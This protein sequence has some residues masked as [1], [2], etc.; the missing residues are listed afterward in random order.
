MADRDL[1][2]T[3]FSYKAYRKLKKSLGEFDAVVEC[4]EIAIREFIEQ[5]E[6]KGIQPYIQ[7]LSKKHK[8]KVD[9]VDFIKFTS[10]I[11]QYYIA[12]VA[13]QFEQFLEDFKGEWEEYFFDVQWKNRNDGEAKLD[14]CLKNIQFTNTPIE[15]DNHIKYYE[16]Y[17]HVR[18][19]MAHTDRDINKLDSAFKKIE[20]L[21]ITNLSSPKSLE[22]IDFE[23]FHVLTNVVKHIAFVI[24]SKSK[25]DNQRIAE[26]LFGLSKENKARAYKGLKKLKADNVRYEKALKSFA[27][28]HFGRFSTNDADD[29]VNKLKCLLA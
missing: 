9:D 25:P 23:D 7:E 18:N 8:V 27:V 22:N 14:N 10:R 2:I 24:C 15:F 16:Y 26:I 5:V 28:T 17:R 29:I 12:S 13:Q 6:K 4:N 1:D 21:F 11:R 19:Y 3:K 20:Q